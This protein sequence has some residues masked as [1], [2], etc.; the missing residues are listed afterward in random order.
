MAWTR[1]FET[2]A[3]PRDYYVWELERPKA[4]L[5]NS[6]F[7]TWDHSTNWVLD[8]P[9]LQTNG[10]YNT[11]FKRPETFVEDYRRLTDL[12]AGL[13]IKG[14]VIWG[15]LRDS[16]GGV[17]Y[18]KRVAS[19]AASKD[20]AIVPGV[21]TTWYGGV[22]YEGDHAANLG[23]FLR[24][25]PDARMLDE[26]GQPR[27]YSGESGA[28]PAHP[29]YQEWLRESLRW[30]CN[31]FEIGGINFENGDFMVDYHPLTQAARR[32]W[33]ADDPEVFFFQGLSYQ[34]AVESV[35][36]RLPDDLI[37]CATYTGFNYTLSAIQNTG[38]G[39]APPA[40]LRMLTRGCAWQWTITGML[41][42]DGLPL[43]AYLDD[44]A[45]AAAFDNTNWPADLRP[46]G[47][48]HVGFMHQGSQWAAE[49][50]LRAGRWECTVSSVKE[51]CLRA[52]RS[53]LE[54]VVIH[55]E[56]TNRSIPNALNYLAFSH[57]VHW[58]EDSMRDF[59]RNTLSQVVGSEDAGETFAVI[60]SHW[61]AGTVTEDMKKESSPANQGFVC[62]PHASC[63]KNADAY[64]RYRFWEW[65]HAM[66]TQGRDR[67]HTSMLEY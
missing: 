49:D 19:Y 52:Y 9:G 31:E 17:E 41:L 59:G 5:P 61:D 36:D 23:T 43:T 64:Q 4:A 15:F 11:Y 24:Q 35:K 10:C 27:Q 18:A 39:M 63:A 58:P 14:I 1:S 67:H 21:G 25:H 44:G 53:G 26:K 16:H 7:W 37:T 54:G 47:K 60:L 51:A 40:M 50:G 55:G 12:A 56:V 32:N 62:R 42:R 30:L 65:L 29:A 46:M 8:D 2:D 48:R 28:S 57:F 13:G 6:Y 33:P 66:A 20:V 38:M 22:Y 3:L 34:Q 45:P